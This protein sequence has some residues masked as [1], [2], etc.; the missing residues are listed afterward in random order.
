[1][2]PRRFRGNGKLAVREAKFA[3]DEVEHGDG[4]I[5]KSGSLWLCV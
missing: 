4:G 3:G 1:M 2:V 5:Q